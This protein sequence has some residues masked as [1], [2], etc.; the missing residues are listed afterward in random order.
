MVPTSAALEVR[1]PARL[2]PSAVASKAVT[3]RA[4]LEISYAPGVQAEDGR[5]G[6]HAH[7][8]GLLHE[9][10]APPHETEGLRE[11]QGIGRDQG[12]V[13]AQAVPGHRGRLHEQALGG[14]GAVDGD[15]RGQERRLGV[16][17]QTEL[18]LGTLPAE[19]R[20]RE[21][22][23]LVGLLEGAAGLLGRVGPG[24]AHAG[25]LRALAGEDERDFSSCHAHQ[26]TTAAPQVEA[27]SATA[28]P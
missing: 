26:R 4:K 5:H 16:R 12:G 3:Q 8:H 2:R 14:Q 25:L 13:L 28:A 6:A 21:A 9:L 7:G 19:A 22:Q 24:A 11:I 20:E 23:D 10:A 15:R 1:V 17:G 27:I 18:L